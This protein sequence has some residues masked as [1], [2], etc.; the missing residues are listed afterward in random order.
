MQFEGKPDTVA[1]IVIGASGGMSKVRKYVT[2]AQVEYTGTFIIQ[3]EIIEPELRCPEFYRRCNGNIFMIA[4]GGINLVVNP[5]NDGAMSYGVTFR[6][7]EQWLHENGLKFDDNNSIS[8]FLISML[9]N[10]DENYK[11]LFRSTTSFVGLPSRLLS[12]DST[13]KADRPLPITVIGDAAH[14]MPPFAG[15]GVNIGMQDALILTDNV[16]NERF[17]TVASA[18]N[19]YEQKMLV[20]A[21]KR[22]QR[23]AKTK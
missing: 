9:D 23:P 18:I 16:T 4:S 5:N 2:D 1:D 8:T 20:Y 19:D 12:L 11:Q 17:D 6:K 15:Q 21:K 14:I 7:P 13:W 10:W 3:G 22:R